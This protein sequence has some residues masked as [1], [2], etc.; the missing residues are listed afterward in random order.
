[1]P[2]VDPGSYIID[3]RDILE[4]SIEE[5]LEWSLSHDTLLVT[6]PAL[7]YVAS[8]EGYGS[9]R[10]SIGPGSLISLG[11]EPPIRYYRL[12]SPQWIDA[13]RIA[14]EPRYRVM[15]GRVSVEGTVYGLEYRNPPAI[16]VN[17][18][19]GPHIVSGVEGMGYAVLGKYKVLD[20]VDGEYIIHVTG[21]EAYRRL[22]YIAPLHST[23]IN[24]AMN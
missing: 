7:V 19:S 24:T 5:I 3:V 16:L 6:A 21:G 11:D 8:M 15:G 13:C 9:L 1:M 18:A 12:N 4:S 2:R 17:G 22:S 20:L 23:C 10:I 14:G